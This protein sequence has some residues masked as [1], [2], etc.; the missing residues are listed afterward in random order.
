MPETLVEVLHKLSRADKLNVIKMLAD[1]LAT[2]EQNS[3]LSSGLQ[4]E[5]WSLMASENTLN[6]LTQLLKEDAA[7]RSGGVQSP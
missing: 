2:D 3:P 5:V 4:P 1:D 7:K 6:T